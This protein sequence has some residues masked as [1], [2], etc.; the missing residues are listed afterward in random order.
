[1]KENRCKFKIDKITC[2]SRGQEQRMTLAKISLHCTLNLEN[3]FVSG[4]DILKMDCK[5]ISVIMNYIG[6]LRTQSNIYDGA[7]FAKITAKCR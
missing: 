5:M 4:M 3:A 1:M 7:F 2:S 6:V